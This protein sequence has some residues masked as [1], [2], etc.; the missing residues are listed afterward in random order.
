MSYRTTARR[1]ATTNREFINYSLDALGLCKYCP[2]HGGDNVR[3]SRSAW[4]KKVAAK[5]MYAT[6]K[7]RKELPKYMR[8]WYD[9][10]YEEDSYE[11]NRKLEN[12]YEEVDKRFILDTLE[13]LSKYIK[14]NKN[15]LTQS[16]I[17]ETCRPYSSGIINCENDKLYISV[18]LKRKRKSRNYNS[19]TNT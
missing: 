1:N 4:G 18:A 19:G 10:H 15:K 8:K 12:K 5:T 16:I 2:P 7:K 9:K 13:N 11:S 6:G 14:V 17:E 3:G